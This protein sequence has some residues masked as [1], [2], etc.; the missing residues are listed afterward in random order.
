MDLSNAPKMYRLAS[1]GMIFAPGVIAWAINGY[2][3]KRDQPQMIAI[4]TQGWNGVPEAAA[5]ALLSK[6]VPYTVEDETVVF[7]A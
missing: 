2:A 6:A 4:I 7:T 5:R 1:A 3:F